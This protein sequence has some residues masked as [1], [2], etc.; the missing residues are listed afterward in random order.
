[1]ITLVVAVAVAVGLV[2]GCSACYLLVRSKVASVTHRLAGVETER[3]TLVRE[4]EEV[5]RQH[6]SDALTLAE[7]RERNANVEA[8]L[9]SERAANAASVAELNRRID[10]LQENIEL[11]RQI[12]TELTAKNAALEQQRIDLGHKS[13]E[14]RT[15]LETRGAEMTGL[16][17]R[18][19]QTSE[20]LAT[21][22]A[23]LQATQQLLADDEKRIEIIRNDVAKIFTSEAAAALAD[24]EKT[25]EK[26]V[27]ERRTAIDS[28]LNPIT[29]QLGAL[30]RLM[31]QF[32]AGRQTTQATLSEKIE[33]LQTSQQDIVAR[34]T[35]K[36]DAIEVAAGSLSTALRNP[37][38]R[39][40]WGE[41][42]LE[43]VLEITGMSEFCDVELQQRLRD[44]MG[45]GQPDAIVRLPR[46]NG[47][48]VP[49]D[50]KV[51]KA[52]F[53]AASQAATDAERTTAM[54]EHA[55]AVLRHAEDLAER[56]YVRY[57]EMVNFV[58][59]FLP[60]E[61]MLHGALTALPD[62]Y[63]RAYGKGVII[64]SPMTLSLYLEGLAAGWRLE[65]QEQNAA[66]IASAAKELYR[67]LGIFAEHFIAVGA[68][69]QK[70]AKS[71]DD[72]VSSYQRRLLVQAQRLDEL[73]AGDS[74]QR[75]RVEGVIQRN[76]ELR[77]VAVAF[78]DQRNGSSAVVV[79]TDEAPE[80]PGTPLS[81]EL[82]S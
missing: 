63:E 49:I 54:R 34:L 43:N 39:G 38:V 6:A 52:Y 25:F 35:A 22:G 80:E 51:P 56:N 48:R 77:A 26:T 37:Q 18:E 31:V 57:P 21:A 79:Q 30:N 72:A 47:K 13:D 60:N 10:H 61:G 70:A 4:R 19:R 41:R 73:G 67:R 68:H 12:N 69:L 7:Q 27:E 3:D 59:L 78:D 55:N 50:A 62:L 23:Q 45:T 8:T 65:R 58:F 32:D 11:T 28:L 17:E 2:V 82:P 71:Y 44:E 20:A 29:E 76:V 9:E 64:T 74:A 81:L 5:A 15:R 42:S 16:R 40:S 14:L 75:P 46:S 24:R 36:A 66:E 33:N 53:L 1:V